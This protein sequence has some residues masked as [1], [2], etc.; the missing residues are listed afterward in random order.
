MSA[1]DAEAS[2]VSAAKTRE[3]YQSRY[4]CNSYEELAARRLGAAA[5]AVSQ[6]PPVAQGMDRPQKTDLSAAE[7]GKLKADGTAAPA[8]TAPGHHGTSATPAHAT[9]VTGTGSAVDDRNAKMAMPVV[10]AYPV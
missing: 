6:V 3:F 4:Q 1:W 10:Y 2:Q 9:P 8:P 5:G 7:A